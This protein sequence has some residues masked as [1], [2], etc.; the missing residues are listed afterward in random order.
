MTIKS[1]LKFLNKIEEYF[2]GIGIL[3]IT[4]ILFL[5]VV[6]RYV[7]NDSIEWAEEVTRYGIIWI[8]FIGASVCIYKGAHLGIDTL[9]LA[10]EKRG[11]KALTF[12]VRILTIVFSIV[13]LILSTQITMKI[14]GTG[15]L[16]AVMRLPMYL[17]YA[18]LPVSGF[19]MTLRFIQEFIEEFLVKKEK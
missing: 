1:Q 16:S 15:Q 11:I 4:V 6:L 17:V 2:I 10:L 7:F 12:I 5:N 18:A 14:Y 13:F 19:L 3:A 9:I 8:T